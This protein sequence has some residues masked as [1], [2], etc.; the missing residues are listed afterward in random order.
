[1]I[2]D[3]K[4]AATV[5]LSDTVLTATKQMKEQRMNSVIITSVSNKPVGILTSKDVL[6]RVVAQGLSPATTNVDKVMTPNPEC[7]GLD[8]TLVDALHTMHDSKFLHLPVVDQGKIL[9]LHFVI[10]S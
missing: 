6:M 4:G 5:S 10:R 8:T 9:V 3:G 7:V 1:L 2:T